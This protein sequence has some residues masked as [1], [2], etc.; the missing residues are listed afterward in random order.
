MAKLPTPEETGEAILQIMKD[1]NI[2]AGEVAPLMGIQVKLGPNYRADD[3]NAALTHLQQ[4][5]L[6]EPAQS[7]FIKL[8]Q[9]GY[10]P[11]PSLDE[12]A[13]AVLD[14]TGEYSIRP[15]DVLPTQ[16]IAIKL[17]QRGYSGSEISSAIESLA[18]DGLVEL[19]DGTPFLTT[20]GFESL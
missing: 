1:M 20:A 2:R 19:R 14:V 12:I 4:K 15:G 5:D 10:G 7:G 13:G 6:I 18:A 8:T 11:E 17:M 16:G 9:A 3:I